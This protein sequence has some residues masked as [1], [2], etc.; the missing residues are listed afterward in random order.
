M[1]MIYQDL[2]T[3][4][5]QKGL[6]IKDLASG[7]LRTATISEIE[8]GIRVPRSQTR[9][10]IESLI[11][12]IDWRKTLSAGGR[13]HILRALAEFVNETGPGNPRERIRFARQALKMIDET[14]N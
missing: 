11:G 3:V 1:I 12:P 10:K 13:Y 6:R 9:K 8:N 14:L 2:R 4:R 7:M 5:I